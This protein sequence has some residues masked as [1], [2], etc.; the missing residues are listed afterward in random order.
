MAKKNKASETINKAIPIFNPLCTAN[1]WLPKYVPSVTTS[2]NQRN[3]LDIS[4]KKAIN[5]HSWELEKPCIVSTPDVVRLKRLRH[6]SIG[7]GDGETRW[8]GWPWK[9]LLC[10]F[11]MFNIGCYKM[12]LGNKKKVY[13]RK[14]KHIYSWWV[15]C[16]DTV[17]P[18]PV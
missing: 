7:Q 11:D 9:L 18:L 10:K 12:R 14:K 3:I 17:K 16:I 1:V 8:K 13:N 2:L 4:S 5:N 15:H 6:V